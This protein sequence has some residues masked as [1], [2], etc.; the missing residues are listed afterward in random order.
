[1]DEGLTSIIGI[2][3]LADMLGADESAIL[4][5]A[6]AQ[7]TSSSARLGI[8]FPLMAGT[9]HL[10][11]YTS[12][13]TTYIRP[14]TAFSLLFDYMGK[15]KFTRQSGNL[16]NNGKESTPVPYDMFHAF[17]EV[18]GEELGWFWKPWF[19][20]LGYA[21]I[22]IGE[23]EFLADKTIVNIETEELSYTRQ[24]NSKVQRRKR[25]ESRTENEYLENQ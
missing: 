6:T 11:D 2:S 13:F 18:A 23:I 12:G 22:G 20:E 17:D 21:D 9:H 15:R 24:F 10:G 19:Y 5:Q 3:A 25:K 8:R 16:Q 4:K 14:I 1:M 7:Y